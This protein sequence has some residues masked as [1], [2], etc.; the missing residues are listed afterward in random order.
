MN[1]I[2]HSFLG[3]IILKILTYIRPD[4]FSMNIELILLA[5]FFSLLPDLSGLWSKK[6]MHNHHT[7]PLHSPFFW[8]LATLVLLV[9]GVPTKYISLP[10]ILLFFIATECHLLSDFITGRYSGIPLLYP[11]SKKE[12]SLRKLEKDNGNI[13]PRHIH[14]K[15]YRSM[16]K[17]YFKNKYLI[18]FEALIWAIGILILL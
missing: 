1:I 11:I 9:V 10:I 2:S 6:E 12:H 14:K 8:I 17:H 3:I 7:S 18:A 16:T 13:N 4:Y 5:I 15:G